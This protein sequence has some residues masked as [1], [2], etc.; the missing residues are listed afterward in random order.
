MWPIEYNSHV[1]IGQFK[2]GTTHAL[3][4]CGGGHCIPTIAL[5]QQRISATLL[6]PPCGSFR[7][8]QRRQASVCQ[9][10]L[11]PPFVGSWWPDTSRHLCF[12][13][14][15]SVRN[16]TISVNSYLMIWSRVYSV[17]GKKLPSFGL[18]SDYMF[19]YISV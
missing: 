4:D 18:V 7:F 11:T 19:L 5:S 12:F 8:V 6:V 13:G 15:G 10:V 16:S 9:S 14:T 2:A 1:F 3:S 17:G